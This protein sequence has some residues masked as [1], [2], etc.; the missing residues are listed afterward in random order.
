MAALKLITA[1]AARVE[2]RAVSIPGK[3]EPYEVAVFRER[4]ELAAVLASGGAGALHPSPERGG[5]P[6]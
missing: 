2:T 1:Q 3:A 6:P 4:S 5:W